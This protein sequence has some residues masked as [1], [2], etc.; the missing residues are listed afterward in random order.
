V[1]GVG[2][3]TP[4]KGGVPIVLAGQVVGAIG[5]SGAASADQDEEIARAAA[6]ALK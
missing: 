5:V 1:V 2:E 3:I 6:A 4:F